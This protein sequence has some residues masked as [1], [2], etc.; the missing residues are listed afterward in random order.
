MTHNCPKVT[1]SY[2]RVTYSE[3]KVT[4]SDPTHLPLP[5]PSTPE[6]HLAISSLKLNVRVCGWVATNF[7]VSSRQ[8]LKLWGLS[9]CRSLPEL[10]KKQFRK[11]HLGKS[12]FW[13]FT[14]YTFFRSFFNFDILINQYLKFTFKNWK[15]PVFLMSIK[16]S[17]LITGNPDVH[18][19]IY[20]YL[21]YF[22]VNFHEDTGSIESHVLSTWDTTLL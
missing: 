13:H 15:C 6:P 18:I 3:P 9:P 4:H 16:Q 19:F 12:N 22:Y 10:L 5:P 1:Y 14:F 7:S 20:F 2:P 11:W 8:G 21:F 17:F